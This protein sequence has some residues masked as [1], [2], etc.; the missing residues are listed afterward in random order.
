[1]KPLG[2]APRRNRY[3]DAQHALDEARD[4]FTR[5]AAAL[6]SGNRL[7]DRSALASA[8]LEGSY[9]MMRLAQGDLGERA[10]DEATEYLKTLREKRA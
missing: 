3:N 9:G 7:H 8:L 10:L 6:T 4:A 1:M 2:A 5:A